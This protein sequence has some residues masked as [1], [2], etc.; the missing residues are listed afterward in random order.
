MAGLFRWV[1]CE[2]MHLARLV[3]SLI[4]CHKQIPR[5]STWDWRS[6]SDSPLPHISAAT[7]LI[8][9]IYLD[10]LYQDLA[11][12]QIEF[13]SSLYCPATNA[14]FLQDGN[15]NSKYK[16]VIFLGHN[17]DSQDSF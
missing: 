10:V 3:Y 2:S 13:G 14:D 16:S 7:L 11:T 17:R 5:Q 6:N 1:I 15:R 4:S 8:Q 12:R 9:I